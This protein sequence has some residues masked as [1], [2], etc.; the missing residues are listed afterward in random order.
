M[1]SSEPEPNYSGDWGDFASF[2]YHMRREAKKKGVDLLVVDTG[3]VS[4]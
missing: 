3:D 1:K 2:V 4:G